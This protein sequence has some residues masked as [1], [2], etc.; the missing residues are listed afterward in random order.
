MPPMAFNAEPLMT[1][2]PSRKATL[3]V[4]A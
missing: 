3:Q 1:G 2:L 4:A